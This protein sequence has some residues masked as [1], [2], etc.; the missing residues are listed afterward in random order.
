MEFKTF[1][2][3]YFVILRFVF[4]AGVDFKIRTIEINGERVKL[5]I[6]DTAGQVGKFL[7]NINGHICFDHLNIL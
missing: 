1:I 2:S 3:L 7:A 4:I 6:W 5:Q